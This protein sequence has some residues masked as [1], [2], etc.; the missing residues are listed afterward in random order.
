MAN[1]ICLGGGTSGGGSNVVPNPQGTA[2]D[3]L[4][5]LGIAGTIYDFA[6]GGGGGSYIDTD[7]VIQ[8]QA[9]IP[10]NTD[11]TYTATQN[12]VVVYY[13]NIS[14]NSMGS[15]SINGVPVDGGWRTTLTGLR[16]FVFLAT[17]QTITLRQTYTTENGF[18][19]VY[20]VLGGSSI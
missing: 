7:T 8:A 13:I 10:A 9:A 19:T 6:G 18:Y 12:C 5:K 1:N 16:G 20:G 4:V 15:V 3:T 11:I 17:G 14:A 2:T